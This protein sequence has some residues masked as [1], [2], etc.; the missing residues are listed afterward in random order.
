MKRSLVEFLIGNRQDILQLQELEKELE[1]KSLN[2]EV[3]IPGQQNDG[4]VYKIFA[5]VD[6]PS[7]PNGTSTMSARQPSGD[8]PA[9]DD[10][11]NLVDKEGMQSL[12]PAEA[13]G[14]VAGS[15]GWNDWDICKM[16]E[17]KKTEEGEKG[18]NGELES[19]APSLV[20]VVSLSGEH[21]ETE[22]AS[23]EDPP[24]SIPTA[25]LFLDIVPHIGTV[26]A[27]VSRPFP[28]ETGSVQTRAEDTAKTLLLTWM[29]MDLD[30]VFEDGHDS[31]PWNFAGD[32][33]PHA[34]IKDTYLHAYSDTTPSGLS[35]YQQS[36]TYAPN[37]WLPQHQFYNQHQLYLAPA[38]SYLYPQYLSYFPALQGP[39]D[40]YQQQEPTPLA[41]ASAPL[42]PSPASFNP[43]QMGSSTPS[44]TP[45][46]D[47]V[48]VI[49]TESEEQDLGKSENNELHESG[50]DLK[51]WM[52]VKR[53]ESELRTAAKVEEV[54][55]LKDAVG[56]SLE[57]PFDSCKTKDVCLSVLLRVPNELTITD[58]VLKKPSKKQCCMM[59]NTAPS[60]KLDATTLSIPTAR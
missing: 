26:A 40:T 23:K 37:T 4:G 56:R 30:F 53:T 1:E 59:E 38:L 47:I 29:G 57:L 10:Q 41:P 14:G 16:E 22:S 49:E 11:K 42:K 24:E 6:G 33:Q 19:V 55:I 13:C 45:D 8:K 2:V 39:P 43:G 21:I 60:R 5:D 25:Q 51:H 46:N 36:Q 31:D 9:L 27:L 28:N 50:Q 32:H 7:I 17:H 44:K 35:Q 34:E 3:V 12:H 15:D 48:Q 18:K 58:R 54:V 20:H 52:K